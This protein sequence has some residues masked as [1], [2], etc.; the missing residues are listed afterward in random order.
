[1]AADAIDYCQAARRRRGTHTSCVWLMQR[2][3]SGSSIFSKYRHGWHSTLPAAYAAP[4]QR[5]A[6]FTRQ[7]R[8][9]TER[10]TLFISQSMPNNRSKS[11]PDMPTLTLSPGVCQV[12][13]KQALALFTFFRRHDGAKTL[14]RVFHCAVCCGSYMTAS[15]DRFTNSRPSSI[16]AISPS[17]SPAS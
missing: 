17:Q 12:A 4:A 3:S 14:I 9:R 1:M 10:Q 5:V 6:A 16:D 2:P 11:L 8:A 13:K 7:Q 15:H